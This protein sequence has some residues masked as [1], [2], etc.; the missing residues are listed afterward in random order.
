LI[1]DDSGLSDGRSPP[2]VHTVAVEVPAADS[3]EVRVVRSLSRVAAALV[4]LAVVVL[5]GGDRAAQQPPDPGDPRLPGTTGPSAVFSPGDAGLGDSYFPA[6]GNGGYDVERYHLDLRYDPSSGR[7][8]GRAVVTAVAT[9][10]LS[11]FNLDFGALDIT[12]VVIDGNNARWRREAEHELVVTPATGLRAQHRFTVE[13]AYGG[14]PGSGAAS[15][16]R[17]TSDGAVVVGEPQAATEWFPSNDHPRDKAAYEFAITVPDGLMAIANGVPGGSELKQGWRTWQWREDAPMA[18]YLATMAVGRFRTFESRYE[19]RPVFSA[20][21]A[22]VPAFVDPA[23]ARTPEVVGFLATQF[24]PY[25][26][27]ALGAIVP[28]DP[29]LSF[30]LEAQ[31][32]PVY[33]QKF[34]AAGPVDDNTVVLAHELTHQWFGDSVS[35]HDWRDIWLN[36]GFATYA[37]WLWEEHLG[38]DT[39]QQTFDRTYASPP[40]AA[41]WTP[42]PGDPGAGRLFARSVYVRGAMTVHALRMTVGDEAFHRILTQWTASRAGSTGTTAQFIALAEAVSGQ[43]LDALFYAWLNTVGK[44]AYP[45]RG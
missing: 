7:L 29:D 22:E 23:I 11:R 33:A 20:V 12:S 21:G 26:F 17:R 6:S 25:P 9:Q 32:R 24:G 18:T 42:P 44:P 3:G 27:D 45:R 28:A 5:A 34:F 37:Q 35:L 8:D 13:V 38:R 19:G 16:F 1:V 39:A 36:E 14:R 2:G 4:L 10:N 30:A 41:V 15:P 40:N 43:R 31:T